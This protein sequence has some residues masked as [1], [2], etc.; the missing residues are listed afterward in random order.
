MVLC[1]LKF[2]GTLFLRVTLVR[3][4]WINYSSTLHKI[5]ENTSFHIRILP[6]KG[7]W[8]PGLLHISC[9]ESQESRHKNNH[10]VKS[11]QIQSFSWSVFS[12]VWTEYQT[13]FT[14]QK[15]S[16][17]CLQLCYSVLTVD[18][19]QIFVHDL[20]TSIIFA[21]RLNK[22]CLAYTYVCVSGG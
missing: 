2:W 20:K 22:R 8:K 5:C 13:W 18:F 17:E 1:F 9:S 16:S 10:C 21:K 7:Q 19:E 11:V 12:C 14:N 3:Y 15:N 4:Q 6:Y